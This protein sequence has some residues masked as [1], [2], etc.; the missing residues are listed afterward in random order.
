MGALKSYIK[1][2]AT[3]LSIFPKM[4]KTTYYLTHSNVNAPQKYHTTNLRQNNIFHIK[5]N[6]VDSYRWNL[7]STNSDEKCTCFFLL[8]SYDKTIK[9]LAPKFDDSII[10]IISSVP[11]VSLFC[12]VCEKY[13]LKLAA[14]SN[15]SGKPKC[16]DAFYSLRS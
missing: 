12:P 4:N 15:P 6:S 8:S 5:S 9:A 1:N 14:K 2:D 10:L 11:I 16:E 3:K 13:I 7:R